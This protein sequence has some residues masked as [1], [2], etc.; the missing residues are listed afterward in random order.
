MKNSEER[1]TE[2][3]EN[4]IELRSEELQDI[5]GRMPTC[6]ERYG[7]IVMAVV[8]A[9][10]LTGTYFFKY[11]DT[12]DAQIVIVNTTP[13]V[14]VVTR[15]SGSLQ[16]VNMNN[17]GTVKANELLVVIGNTADYKDV[18]HV[19]S[20]IVK[21]ELGNIDLITF[22][23][24]AKGQKWQLGDL[25]HYFITLCNASQNLS[26]YRRNAY[27]P[28]KIS[29][30]KERLRK[31]GD[32]EK[33]KHRQHELQEE[34]EKLSKEVFLRDSSLFASGML[35][36]EDY[37]KARQTY[38]LSLKGSIERDME[39]MQRDM[40]RDN[41]RETLLDL[42]NEHFRSTNEYEQA[43]HSALQEMVTA[44]K[45]WEETY[46][47]RSPTEGILNHMGILGVNRYIGSNE[48]AFVITP[49]HQETPL[50]KAMLP[51]AGAGKVKSGQRVIV[52]VNNFPEEE[53]GSL[54]G[55]I[56]SISNTPTAEGN[57]IVDI[58]FPNGLTTVFHSELPPTQQLIGTARL[59]IKERRLIDLFIQPIRKILSDNT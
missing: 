35:S 45:K 28:Q 48:T 51:A 53:F 38:T 6:F 8:I 5:I 7:I 19:E 11:P 15:T 30:T 29:V 42:S 56:V 39:D 55:R 4:D 21:L 41:D 24:S 18:F 50:G 37:G 57:Y 36:Q 59:V 14:N 52:A 46:V 54:T 44:I 13:P 16:Y 47:L 1:L 9:A 20:L 3:T 2:E 22:V 17:G 27:Y 25:Q 23:N 58:D 34:Q 43:F 40:Q 12:L 32:M 10:L 26:D 49:C 31:R 33:K